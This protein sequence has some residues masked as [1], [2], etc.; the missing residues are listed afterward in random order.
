MK[1]KTMKLFSK[2]LILSLIFNIIM[3]GVTVKVSSE[4]MSYEVVLDKESGRVLYAK[5][6][7][8]QTLFHCSVRNARNRRTAVH[9]VRQR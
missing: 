2:F 8:I 7:N 5:N 3:F 9:F 1:N 6:E 4:N